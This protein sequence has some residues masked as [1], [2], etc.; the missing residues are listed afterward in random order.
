MSRGIGGV[1][2]AIATVT[3]A[4]MASTAALV[5]LII[6]MV[7][8]AALLIGVMWLANTQDWNLDAFRPWLSTQ[9]ELLVTI[10]H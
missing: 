10:T 7:V 1:A 2:K 8:V 3:T 4:A 6:V 5:R 9:Q